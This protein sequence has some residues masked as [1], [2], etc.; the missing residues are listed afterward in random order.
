MNTLK[1]IEGQEKDY[2]DK[3]TY[4]S[5]T[6]NGDNATGVE[7]AKK[8][9]RKV[10]NWHKESIRQIIEAEIERKKIQK[11]KCYSGIGC[12]GTTSDGWCCAK[13]RDMTKII[14]EDIKHL[15]NLLDSLK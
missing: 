2:N 4:A 15:I 14:E 12:T 10:F 9:K 1:I 6:W 5:F 3:F 8:A 13:H 11:E 7:F